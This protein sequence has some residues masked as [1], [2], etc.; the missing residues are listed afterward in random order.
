[1]GPGAPKA[2]LEFESGVMDMGL[3]IKV[4]KVLLILHLRNLDETTLARKVYEEQ[5]EQN[6]PGLAKETK[7]ICEDLG[8]E[9]CNI[10]KSSQ[11]EY[12]KLVKLA[13]MVTNDKLQ[14]KLAEG[15][16]KCER[17]MN[18]TYGR[19][20]Y[21]SL[22]N[23]KE[24]R[25]MFRTRVGLLPFAG[26]YGHDNRYARTQWLCRC[27][28]DREEERHLAAGACPVYGDLAEGVDMERDE[29][30]KDFFLSVLARREA[31][32]EMDKE[33][34]ERAEMEEDEGRRAAGPLI[35]S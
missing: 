7:K 18:D 11:T 1:V 12:R 17:I 14:R 2:A 29:E 20:A 3:R 23:I 30:L 19:K 27:E 35:S 26:N 34:E 16:G 24:A 21:F 32:D 4:E 31:L 33:E 13:C 5:K 10:T 28:T 9:D 15:K 25:Q 8:I 6:W 22:K